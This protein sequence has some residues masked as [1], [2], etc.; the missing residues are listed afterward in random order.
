MRYTG[1]HIHPTEKAVSPLLPLIESFSFEGDV[2]LDLFCGSGSTLVAARHL[3]RHFIGMELD[4]TTMRS[5]HAGHKPGFALPAHVSPDRPEEEN[6]PQE[7]RNEA[8]GS[9]L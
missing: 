1:N 9:G 5:Q 6:S 7:A 4:P 3:R 2:V 8:P